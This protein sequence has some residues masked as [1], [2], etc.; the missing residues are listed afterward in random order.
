MSIEL[1]Y[2]PSGDLGSFVSACSFLVALCRALFERVSKL[3]S[4]GRQSF[5]YGALQ[6]T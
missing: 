6:Y 5:A 2:P 3:S 4:E 1:D